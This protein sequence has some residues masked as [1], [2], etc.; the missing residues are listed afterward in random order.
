[1]PGLA[2]NFYVSLQYMPEQPT[3]TAKP[4]EPYSQPIRARHTV[5]LRTMV[6]HDTSPRISYLT[7]GHMCV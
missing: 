2:S 4:K 1:M 7:N 3:V 5:E 6:R